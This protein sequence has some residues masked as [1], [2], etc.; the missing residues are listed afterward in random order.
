M[1]FTF[2]N[3]LY[4]IGKNFFSKKELIDLIQDDLIENLLT[5]DESIIERKEPSN[6]NLSYS[7]HAPTQT[8]YYGVPGS[9]KSHKIDE[10]TKNIPDEQKIRVVFHPEYTNADFV[11]QIFCLLLMAMLLSTLSSREH[12]L[13]FLLQHSKIL[14]SL[15]I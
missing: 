13:E 9:G 4:T 7:T 6:Q 10:Q 14:K 12:L 11:G 3:G 15:I 1:N 8:I 5:K 2:S